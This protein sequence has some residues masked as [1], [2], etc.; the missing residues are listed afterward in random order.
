MNII[1]FKM[2]ASAQL[3]VVTDG[4]VTQDTIPLKDH[5]YTFMIQQQDRTHRIFN[6]RFED[7]VWIASVINKAIISESIISVDVEEAEQHLYILMR[8]LEITHHIGGLLCDPM[9]SDET[10]QYLQRVYRKEMALEAMARSHLLHLFEGVF[11]GW[12]CS[13]S[14]QTS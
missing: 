6:L 1:T 11:S 9:I 8:E 12:E 2:Q 10:L 7:G 14:L 13:T 4:Y 3:V 5:E